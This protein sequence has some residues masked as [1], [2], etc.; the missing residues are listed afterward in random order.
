M[1]LINQMLKDLEKRRAATM[2]NTGSSVLQGVSWPGWRDDHARHGI[3]VLLLVVLCVVISAA[4]F[5]WYQGTQHTG[6]AVP[7]EVTQG[8]VKKETYRPV[9]PTVVAVATVAEKMTPSSAVA[10]EADG[11]TKTYRFVEVVDADPGTSPATAQPT[12]VAS[13]AP[14]RIAA[15]EAL[16]TTDAASVNNNAVERVKPESVS[17]QQK[18]NTTTVTKTL[19]PLS[20]EQQAEARYQ[21]ALRYYNTSQYALAESELRKA[22]ALDVGHVSARELLAAMLIK[23]GRYNSVDE[24]LA[25][26]LKMFP[27]QLSFIQLKARMFMEQG[28]TAAAIQMLEQN[29]PAVEAEP[30]YYALRAA[31]YQR[32]GQHERAVEAY[33]RLVGLDNAAPAWW[34]GLAISQEAL[35]QIKP[36]LES[37]RHAAASKGLNNKLHAYVSDRIRLL[38]RQRTAR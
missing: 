25:E 4:G 1:S 38:G 10:P 8:A 12:T 36:A 29:E 18:S 11:K 37:Y 19:R 17:K 27:Q 5:V 30:A 23:G 28:N 24:L 32:D 9:A 15:P 34:I 13:I 31:L 21:R 35:G 26:G 16:M 2:S 20:S 6:M 7:L 33:T 14:V 3:A 22:L